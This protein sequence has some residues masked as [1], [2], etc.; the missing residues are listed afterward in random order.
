M[1]NWCE[2]SIKVR[3]KYEDVVKF[4]KEGIHCYELKYGE[5]GI[6]ET[7][8]N[9]NIRYYSGNAYT[10]VEIKANAYIE[11][12][13]RGFI[14][15]QVIDI[16][17]RENNSALALANIRQAWDFNAKEY[18]EISKKYDI[19]I[20]LYGFERGMCFNREIEVIR[21]EITIDNNIKFADYD[22]ECP[23]P[24]IGG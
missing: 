7:I 19:D 10:T 11:G 18:A 24:M 21:G 17:K 9:E 20:R 16:D 1:P 5:T 15:R 2:G 22:W 12:T 13:E 4:F 8:N 6:S 23:M 14:D 3:G